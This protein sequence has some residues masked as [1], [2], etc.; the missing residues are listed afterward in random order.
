MDEVIFDCPHITEILVEWQASKDPALEGQILEGCQSLVEALVSH[1]DPMYRDDLIQEAFSRI[2][3]ACKYFMPSIGNLHN[4]LTSVINNTC[5]TYLTKQAKYVSVEDF[6]E[7]P[8]DAEAY[9]ETLQA[10]EVTEHLE[11]LLPDLKARNRMRFP[12]LPAEDLD[13][14]SEA[15]YNALCS[16]GSYPKGLAKMLSETRRIPITV[17]RTVCNSS[18]IWMRYTNLSNA[19]IHS[20]HIPEL[21]L[22]KDLEE[23]VD[24]K[25]FRKIRIVF[26]GMLLRVS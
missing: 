23:I 4:Y 2:L 8:E 13:S 21:T 24:E 7:N 25:T 3:Y 9:I 18:L 26:S 20:D 11:L 22:L 17:A 14:I 1:F 6:M 12:T 10:V 15:V 5:I 19:S 16:N